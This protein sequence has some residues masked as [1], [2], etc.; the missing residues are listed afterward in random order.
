MKPITTRASRA[1]EKNRYMTSSKGR[2]E[3]DA[4]TFGSLY[5][6]QSPEATQ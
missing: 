6:I 4:T 5:G 1:G 3:I 2:I